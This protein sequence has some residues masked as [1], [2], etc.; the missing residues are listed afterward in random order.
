MLHPTEVDMMT[1][2]TGEVRDVSLGTFRFIAALMAAAAVL[3]LAG[4]I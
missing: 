2:K 3:L 1:P 4:L